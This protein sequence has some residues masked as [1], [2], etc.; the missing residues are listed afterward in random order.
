MIVAKLVWAR[1]VRVNWY[2]GGCIRIGCIL[3]N[4]DDILF[5]IYENKREYVVMFVRLSWF[6]S[7]CC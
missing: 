5:V 2:M 3:T 1:V 7:R 4:S 6:Y